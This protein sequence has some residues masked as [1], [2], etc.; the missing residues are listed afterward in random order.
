MHPEERPHEPDERA[1]EQPDR[2]EQVTLGRYGIRRRPGAGHLRQ[3]DL[4]ALRV[5]AR[6]LELLRQL[7]A[8]V[9]RD[10]HVEQQLLYLRL[11]LGDAAGAARRARERAVERAEPRGVGRDGSS[12]L[13]G[14]GQQRRVGRVDAGGVDV[15]RAPAGLDVL[16]RVGARRGGGELRLER[17]GRRLIGIELSLR[18][19]DLRSERVRRATGERVLLR[20]GDDVVGGLVVRERRAGLLLGGQ[21]LGHLPAQV[22]TVRRRLGAEPGVA[23]L[24]Q[25]V[26]RGVGDVRGRLGDRPAPGDVER[27]TVVHLLGAQSLR[28]RLHRGLVAARALVET[29][30]QVG[31]RVLVDARDRLFDLHDRPV[32]ALHRLVEVQL[33]DHDLGDVTVLDQPRLGVGQGGG[34]VRVDQSRLLCQSGAGAVQARRV[35][36]AQQHP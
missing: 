19:I 28:H 9:A 31:P 25:R 8:G 30:R 3:L 24:Y 32:L 23:L 27:E 1:E 13:L 15:R 14:L 18:G 12:R 21:C 7:L 20:R 29:R 34:E 6:S 26:G 33:I 16:A 2:E 10:R 4:R 35:T 5:H 11:L 22:V 17:R 36:C